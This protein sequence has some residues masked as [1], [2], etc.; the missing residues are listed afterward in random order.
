[1]DRQADE[2][3]MLPAYVDR[4]RESFRRVAGELDREALSRTL[5]PASM[6]LGGMIKHLAFVESWWFGEVL[7]GEPAPEPF[8]AVD[9]EV[10]RDWEW[11]SALD[12]DPD[13]L[14]ELYER[15][16]RR[17]RDIVAAA[18]AADGPAAVSVRP[19]RDGTSF[20]LRWILLHVLEE[21]ARHL[22]HADLIRESIDGRTG[23]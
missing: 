8:A 23:L 20:S 2:A 13:D 4:Q 17:S 15:M 19:G 10:D 14:W 12:D 9:R 18:M 21:Y 6:T 11:H 5:P 16:V 3:T 1:M 22:G 7:R